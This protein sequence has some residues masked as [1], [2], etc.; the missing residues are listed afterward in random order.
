[1]QKDCAAAIFAA[2]MDIVI[3]DNYK[4][5]E[6]IRA[7]EFFVARPARHHHAP[8]VERTARIVAPAVAWPGRAHRRNPSFAQN[9]VGSE[10]AAEKAKGSAR[11]CA[12]ALPLVL[13]DPPA[14]NCAANHDRPG[15]QPAKRTSLRLSLARQACRPQAAQPTLDLPLPARKRFRRF[16]CNQFHASL[17]FQAIGC[18]SPVRSNRFQSS[19]FSRRAAN[20]TRLKCLRVLGPAS[21]GKAKEFRVEPPMQYEERRRRAAGNPFQSVPGIRTQGSPRTSS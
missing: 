17:C 9:P 12:I 16:F 13:P 3:E 1:M 18:D 10:K 19:A 20:M 15:V 5:V 21:R 11:R 14:A 8:V 7:P 4:I 2:R 6:A